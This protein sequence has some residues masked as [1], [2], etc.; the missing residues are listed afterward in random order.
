MPAAGVEFSV[1]LDTSAINN[2]LN[3][4]VLGRLNAII[5]GAG[6]AMKSA[7]S[8]LVS[9][10]KEAEVRGHDPRGDRNSTC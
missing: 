5:K 7:G 4:E 8:T 10:K 1:V 2:A 6:D 9:S 3:K